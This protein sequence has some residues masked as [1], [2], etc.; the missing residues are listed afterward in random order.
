MKERPIL[1][2]TEMVNAILKGHKTM[3]RRTVN[4]KNDWLFDEEKNWPTCIY[5][6]NGMAIVKPMKCPYG[7]V[8]DRL[9]V[10][11]TWQHTSVLNIHESDENS[12][13]IY[14]A[15]D[16][17]WDDFEEWTWRPSIFMPREACRILLEITHVRCERLSEITNSEAMLEGVEGFNPGMSTADFEQAS[18]KYTSP[19]LQFVKL[20]DKINGYGSF[21]KN[22]AVWVV[23]F[24]RI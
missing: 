23:E 14:K 2:S 8:G 9:W 22:P 3:T 17:D 4:H 5:N 16:P 1:F 24:K 19:V 18:Q 6:E 13:Y 10:R 12:G 15:T 11:E 7:E 21:D 20:W